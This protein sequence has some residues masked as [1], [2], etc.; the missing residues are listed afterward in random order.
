MSK[1]VW[2]KGRK[3]FTS[4]IAIDEQTRDLARRLALENK[5]TIKGI[6]A[7]ALIF[8]ENTDKAL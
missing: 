3:K 8:W 7:M 5:V 6:V 1:K 4:T 2:A